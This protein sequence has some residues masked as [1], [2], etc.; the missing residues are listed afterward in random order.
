MYT[1]TLIENAT[2]T[3]IIA[4]TKSGTDSCIIV[5]GSHLDSVPAGP[6]MNDNGSGS[7][8]NLEL[9]IQLSKL[10]LLSSV[11]N[12]IRFAWWGAEELG[13]LG[14]DY[15]VSSLSASDLS[16]I[17]LNLNFDMVASPNYFR[18]IYNASSG[19]SDIRTQSIVI[20]KI[21]EQFF[22]DNNLDYELTAFNGRSDYGP[23]ISNGIPAGGL[24]TGA[25]KIKSVDQR[26]IYG[27]IPNAAF[28][29]CYH[30]EC[31]TINNINVDVYQQMAQAAG[32]TLQQLA[33]KD[34]LRDFLNNG[35]TS[36]N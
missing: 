19:D 20:Q 4:E 5:V 23:F 1:E 2:S 14:S 8:L 10:G 29:T 32:Y 22:I 15:Y 25:E 21:F 33:F 3:N 7:S 16:N 18:G 31:D 12:K 34:N 11:K 36:C 24:E 13:L 17:C 6:G 9:M 30:L 28:D 26:T 27:G 35:C